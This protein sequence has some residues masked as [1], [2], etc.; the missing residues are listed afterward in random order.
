M[1][2]A[3]ICLQ[4]LAVYC[5]SR[6]VSTTTWDFL[7]LCVDNSCR[8]AQASFPSPLPLLRRFRTSH[9]GFALLVHWSQ[10]P[11]GNRDSGRR[12]VP[13]NPCRHRGAFA[14]LFRVLIPTHKQKNTIPVP[15]YSRGLR[16]EMQASFCHQALCLSVSELGRLTDNR[17]MRRVANAVLFLN[18]D[19]C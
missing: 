11:A 4:H 17:R 5:S 3:I 10:Q 8:L 1:A 16:Y 12:A 18:R 6:V 7:C 15:E 9:M 2:A 19:G 13:A 14:L